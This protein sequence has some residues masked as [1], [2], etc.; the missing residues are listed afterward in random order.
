MLSPTNR[1]GAAS[2]ISWLQNL[3]LAHD[4][5]LLRIILKKISNWSLLAVRPL[6]RTQNATFTY[7]NRVA[8]L[9]RWAIRCG[10]Q[11]QTDFV[12]KNQL[13]RLPAERDARL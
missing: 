1:G 10:G 11:P 8:T 9:G 2:S 6:S 12:N 5:E 13:D 7:K 4:A 3:L